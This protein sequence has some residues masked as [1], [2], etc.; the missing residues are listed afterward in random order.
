M[1]KENIYPKES[2]KRVFINNIKKS[3]TY[4]KLTEKEKERLEKV[5]ISTITEHSI[6]GSFGDRYIVLQAIYNSFLMA[7]D[8]EPI[9]WREE[10]ED[11]PLF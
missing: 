3:W 9:G 10:D 11:I 1:G 7:L 6:K 2:A 8:Y 4:A 5:F